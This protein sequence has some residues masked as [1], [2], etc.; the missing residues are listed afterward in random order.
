[1]PDLDVSFVIDD[2]MFSDTI[3]VTRRTDTIGTNGRTTQT[4]TTFPDIN[5]VVTQQDP[6]D[7]M[8]GE[9]GQ[10]VPRLI[11]L[12]SRFAFRGAVVGYQPDLVTW[13]GTDYLV[14]QTYPYSRFGEGF[15]EAVAESMT[16]TDVPQ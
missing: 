15:Y 9:A 6:A 3:V 14:K 13:N 4:L 8:R 12:A 5:A 7:L 10:V 1:M 11:F 2:P 16:A